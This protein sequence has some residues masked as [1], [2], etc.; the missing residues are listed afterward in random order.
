MFLSLLLRI[1]LFPLPPLFFH[2]GL[3]LARNILIIFLSRKNGPHKQP[4]CFFFAHYYMLSLQPS[5]FLFFSSLKSFSIR[6]LLRSL[7]E[8]S[9]KCSSFPPIDSVWFKRN[10]GE[11]FLLP[12]R[13]TCIKVICLQR[14]TSGNTRSHSAKMH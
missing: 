3:Y 1:T 8:D 12:P 14:W 5:L 4:L 13:L 10:N 11:A 2:N 9:W 6:A 7:G